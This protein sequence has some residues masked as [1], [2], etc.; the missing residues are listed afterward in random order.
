MN[1]LHFSDDRIDEIYRGNPPMTA[2]ERLFLVENTQTFE[3]CDYTTYDLN[4][5]T[6]Q[7]LMRFCYGVWADYASGQV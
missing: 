2:D 7:A 4:G 1:V 6:D 5:M 3:E